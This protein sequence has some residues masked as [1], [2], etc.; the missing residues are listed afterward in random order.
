MSMGDGIDVFSGWFG[1]RAFRVSDISLKRLDEL[2]EWADLQH[3]SHSDNN[4][5]R[6]GVGMCLNRASGQD[7]P[8]GDTSVRLLVQERSDDSKSGLYQLQKGNRLQGGLQ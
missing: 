5:R 7:F 8:L 4:G 1:T 3:L 2:I 6:S